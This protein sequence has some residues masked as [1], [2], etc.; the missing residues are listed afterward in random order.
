MCCV[1]SKP[2][3]SIEVIESFPYVGGKSRRFWG[4]PTTSKINQPIETFPLELR[5][6]EELRRFLR[7]VNNDEYKTMCAIVSSILEKIKIFCDFFVPSMQRKTNL[8]SSVN[9]VIES[10]NSSACDF[11]L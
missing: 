1:F 10:K 5:W 3:T 6:K 4:N 8:I 2:L 9:H 11:L 7:R